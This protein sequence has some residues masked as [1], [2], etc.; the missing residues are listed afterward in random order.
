MRQNQWININN[1]T[2]QSNLYAMIINNLRNLNSG[3]KLR[4][5]YALHYLSNVSNISLQNCLYFSVRRIYAT[6]LGLLTQIY[7]VKILPLFD[8]TV[9]VEL[10]E[11][12]DG[13]GRLELL[14]LSKGAE[15]GGKMATGRT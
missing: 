12:E 2:S 10:D 1:I 6:T 13:D 8:E 7:D 5:P 15:D 4:F 11:L 14:L 9:K 3:S